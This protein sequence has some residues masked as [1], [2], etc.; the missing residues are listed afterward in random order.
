L[1]FGHE[2]NISYLRIF[3]CAVYISIYLPQHIK[4]GPQKR[5]GIYIGFESPSIIK[6]LEPLTGDLFMT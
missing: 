5:L 4:M 2:P 3:G 1:V 6:Y